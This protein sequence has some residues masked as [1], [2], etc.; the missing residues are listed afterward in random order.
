MSK[1]GRIRSV[2]E[3]VLFTSSQVRNVQVIIECVPTSH[4]PPFLALSGRFP[5]ESGSFYSY[6]LLSCR[7]EG[8]ASVLSRTPSSLTAFRKERAQCARRASTVRNARAK[9]ARWHL[10]GILELVACERSS[11]PVVMLA[12][13]RKKPYNMTRKRVGPKREQGRWKQVRFRAP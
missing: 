1:P 8:F 9:C 10:L 5:L 6:A 12:A 3:C 2:R 7:V 4:T 11:I 13:S